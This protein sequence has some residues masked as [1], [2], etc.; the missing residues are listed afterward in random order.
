[1]MSLTFSQAVPEEW[2]CGK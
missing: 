1:M 2:C